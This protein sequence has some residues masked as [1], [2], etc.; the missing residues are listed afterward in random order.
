MRAILLRELG[1]LGTRHALFV[2]RLVLLLLLALVLGIAIYGSAWSGARG[3]MT[4]RGMAEV[5]RTFFLT[6]YITELILV[7]LL[8]AT[9]TGGVISQEREAR[10]LDL[11]LMAPPGA[12]RILFGKFLSRIAVLLFVI[13]YSAPFLFAGLALGGVGTDEMVKAIVH[14]V[15]HGFLACGVTFF[16]SATNRNPRNASGGTIV[17]VF[18]SGLLLPMAEGLIAAAFQQNRPS[19]YLT[20]YVHPFYASI[21]MI[22]GPWKLWEWEWILPAIWTGAGVALALLA[23]R[24]VAIRT[25]VNPPEHLNPRTRAARKGLE[26]IAAV[27]R[28]FALIGACAIGLWIFFAPKKYF[29]SNHLIERPLYPLAIIALFIHVLFRRARTGL[30]QGEAR[31]W[32]TS[33]PPE[34]NPMQWKEAT[35]VGFLP[36]WRADL[37]V[38]ACLLLCLGV[39]REASGYGDDGLLGTVAGCAL[40]STLLFVL[41]QFSVAFAR[42]REKKTLDLLLLTTAPRSTLVD[43]GWSSIVRMMWPLFALFAAGTVSSLLSYSF[44][45]DPAQVALSWAIVLAAILLHG[46][47]ALWASIRTKKANSA[48]SLGMGIP[49]LAY[50][51]MPIVD[52]IFMSIV[53]SR[54]QDGPLSLAINPVFL[55]IYLV[56][57]DHPGTL[58]SGLPIAVAGILY[59]VGAVVLSFLLRA[60]LLARLEAP[61]DR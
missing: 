56:V 38:L 25:Y 3:G 14:V 40:I 19:L 53:D 21:G 48:I 5:G 29:Y 32:S 52:G 47:W 9:M 24:I 27:A 31:A 37:T 41:T 59:V 50:T 57:Q 36:R 44:K 4:F 39:A 61:P 15:A 46:Y 58:C 51:I 33:L 23:G 13:A 30:T 54:M 17:L 8:V 6:F 35:F 11:L 28:V 60:S 10:T 55:A 18:A 1:S 26:S 2:V 20:A 12:M 34:G 16:L 42:E 7:W 43:G 45:V 49:L 22:T